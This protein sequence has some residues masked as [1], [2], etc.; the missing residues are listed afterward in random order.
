MLPVIEGT[1]RKCLI[2]SRGQHKKAEFNISELLTAFDTMSKQYV[3]G[4][5][6]Y[7]TKKYAHLQAKGEYFDQNQEDQILEKHKEYFDLW[8]GQVTNYLKNNLYLDTRKNVVKDNLNRHVIFHALQDD[9][10]FSFRNYL[11]LFN[12]INFLSWSIGLVTEGCSVLSEA[13]EEEVFAIW[14]NYLRILMVSEAMTETKAS[15]YGKPI[16]SFERFLHPKYHEPIRLP[17]DQLKILLQTMTVN[18]H[19]PQIPTYKA[20]PSTNKIVSIIKF[21]FGRQK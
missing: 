5:R 6:I 7:L 4:Q 19:R 8:I 11:R 1:L 3:D 9:I 12:C 10:D 16:E 20:T 2:D 21:I 14:N 18:T 17:A 13:N 15:I